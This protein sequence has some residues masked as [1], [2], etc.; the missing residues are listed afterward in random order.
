MAV[1]PIS[2]LGR[3]IL[4]TLAQARGAVA[5]TDIENRLRNRGDL[6]AE[7]SQLIRDGTILARGTMNEQQLKAE[8]DLARSALVEAQRS[9]TTYTF[10]SANQFVIELTKT[11][12]DMAVLLAQPRP[13]EA[14]LKR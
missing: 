11:G 10:K 14:K 8:I 9:G 4:T 3:L 7:L 1:K 12:R 6:R 13:S 2:D 5:M